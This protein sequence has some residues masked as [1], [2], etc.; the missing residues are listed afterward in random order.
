MSARESSRPPSPLLAALGRAALASKFLAALLVATV[1]VRFAVAS[2]QHSFGASGPSLPASSAPRVGPKA[3]PAASTVRPRLPASSAAPIRPGEPRSIQLGISAGAERSEI[4]VNG[5]LL[6][7]TPFVGDTSC[8]T[9]MPLRIELVPPSGPPLV[10]ERECRGAV[11]EITGG[12][13]S[14]SPRP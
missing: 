7:K 3:P 2:F 12:P 9:G 4:Y 1:S 11:V 5:R 6:G 8:K 10:Y 14:S 13:S